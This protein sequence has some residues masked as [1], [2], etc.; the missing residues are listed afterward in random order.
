MRR[1]LASALCLAAFMLVSCGA[2]ETEPVSAPETTVTVSCAGDCTLASDASF[3]GGTFEEVL[4]AENDDYSY[5]FKNVKNIFEE[6]D[7]TIVNLEG[8]L[9][10]NGER[11]DKTYAF[12]GKPEYTEILKSGSVEGV[13]LANNHSSDYGE[14]SLRDTKEALD[15]A[16][17]KYAKDSEIARFN[18][19][20]AKVAVVGL[21]QLDESADKL[22]DPVMRETRDD[23]LV[24]VEIHWGEEKAEK[25]SD[26]QIELAHKAVDMGA[27]LVIGHH[28]HVLQGVEKYN[29]KYICYSL[30]NFCFGGN[31]NPS[32]T[33]TMIFRQTFRF[34]EGMAANTDEY[35]IIPCS[36]TSKSD[37]NYQPKVLEGE[38]KTRVEKKIID[39][40][41]QVR[42]ITKTENLDLKFR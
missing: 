31:P 11:A 5:F 41:E 32:D 19:N 2:D 17:I 10:E 22:I 6:D 36:I 28:P 42:Q 4:E 18:I 40:S 27:D 39:R 16:G 13:T 20:G 33:D 9:S 25:P 8:T 23:D 29:G 37:N 3:S 34:R 12:R 21:Y 7:L 26:E 30:G 38:Q 35:E 24:I 15:K 14:V 1:F